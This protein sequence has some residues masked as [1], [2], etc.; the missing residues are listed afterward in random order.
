ME[1]LPQSKLAA[2]ADC[3]NIKNEK[4]KTAALNTLNPF[5]EDYSL[6]AVRL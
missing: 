1:A 6:N 3:A 4:Q 2:Q 5:E